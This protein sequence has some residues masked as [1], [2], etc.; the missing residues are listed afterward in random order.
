MLATKRRFEPSVIQRLLDEPQRFQFF[1]AVRLLELWLRDNDVPHGSAVS[2]YL[3]FRNSLSLSFPASEIEDL[4]ADAE[5]GAETEPALRQALQKG[6]LRHVAITPPFMGF[7]GGGGA[8]PLHYTERIAEHQLYQRDDS[9]RAFLDAFSNR[10]VALFYEA[11]RKYRLEYKYALDATDHFLPLLKSFAGIGQRGLGKR[12]AEEQRGVLDE[13]VG[14][15]AVAFRHRP[16]SAAMMRAVLEDYFDVH[17]VVEQFVGCWYE[18][19][20]QQQTMLGAENAVLGATA[21]AGARVWQRDLRMR[22][23]IGP[24]EKKRFEAFLPHGPAAQALEKLLKMFTS[25]CLEYEVQLIL[26]AS[27]VAGATLGA[28]ARLGWD[29]FM[30][31]AG[32][33]QDRGDVRYLVHAI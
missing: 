6:T 19:P 10:A 7:L 9:P 31:A 8:L 32:Q 26:R 25:L 11:W 27:D 28:G 4:Y 24:L 5:E 20:R 12:L 23:V 13:T 15:Y 21:M 22:L 1:Q 33:S 14:C 17:V 29:T 3:R 18:V 16:A 30:A 2:E